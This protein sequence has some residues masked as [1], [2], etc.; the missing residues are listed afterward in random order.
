M[1]YPEPIDQTANKYNKKPLDPFPTSPTMAIPFQYMPPPVEKISFPRTEM[2]Y[3]R[4]CW[5]LVLV[6]SLLAII[7]QI[8]C[9]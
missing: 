4:I 3:S 1:K 9:T 8:Y 6:I 5:E 7:Y 2:S